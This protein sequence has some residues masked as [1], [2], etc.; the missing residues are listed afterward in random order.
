MKGKKLLIMKWLPLGILTLVF[1]S[2]F[3]LTNSVYG[4]CSGHSPSE[5]GK[6]LR[7]H[8][9]YHPPRRWYGTTMDYRV[10]PTTRSWYGPDIAHAA[11]QWN[12]AI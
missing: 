3:F 5:N 1:W 12:E 4:Q 7:A 10:Q 11:A 6:N 8:M 2:C 9:I